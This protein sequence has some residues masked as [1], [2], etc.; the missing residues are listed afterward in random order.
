[1]FPNRLSVPTIAPRI[2]LGTVLRK[3][4]SMLDDYIA[5]AMITSD[6]M[7]NARTVLGSLMIQKLDSAAARMQK[8]AGNVM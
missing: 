8:A 2:S 5:E 3:R 1:M 4:A 7:A 6:D